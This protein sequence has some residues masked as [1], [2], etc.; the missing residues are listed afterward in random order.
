MGW[1]GGDDLLRQASL[2]VT[3]QRRSVLTAVHDHP[4]TDTEHL[5][6]VVRRELGDVSLQAVYDALA[7]FTQ[8][9]LVR[10]IEPAGSPARYELQT[11]DNHH[12][13]VCRS[14]GSIADVPCAV[15]AAPC[16]AGSDTHGY[17]IDE[18]E[19]TFWGICPS[20]AQSEGRSNGRHQ[21]PHPARTTAQRSDA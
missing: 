15:G 5:A 2:R 13:I 10:R 21:I 3:R 6:G 9:G 14:C 17:L 11:G 16:L 18:A 7:A 4:H 20:C 1:T 12:H 19:V 8:R